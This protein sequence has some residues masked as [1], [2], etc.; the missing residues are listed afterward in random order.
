M[1]LAVMTRASLGHTGQALRAGAGTQALYSLV[2][3]AAAL[4]VIAGLVGSMPLIWLA[5]GAWMSAFTGFVVLYGPT[6]CRNRP[7]WQT[8]G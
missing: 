8:R 6:L 1:A 5:A 3:C 4:R 2:V 7:I